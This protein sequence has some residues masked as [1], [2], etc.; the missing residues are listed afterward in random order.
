MYIIQFFVV[1]Q[2][3]NHLLID[4]IIN[5]LRCFN[6]NFLVC[7]LEV[8]MN[9]LKWIKCQNMLC[10]VST[11][12]CANDE[13]V[14]SFSTQLQQSVFSTTSTCST[15]LCPNSATFQPV[16]TWYYQKLTFHLNFL[17]PSSHNSLRGNHSIHTLHSHLLLR[18][19]SAHSK[20]VLFLP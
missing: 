8:V 10:F 17:P 1:L 3:C 11:P 20:S 5:H 15:E 13:N 4:I 18:S 2:Q 19:T 12:I 6:A 16:P 14:K 9:V 7:N